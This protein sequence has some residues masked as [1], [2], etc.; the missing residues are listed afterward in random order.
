M[1]YASETSGKGTFK[2]LQE[3]EPKVAIFTMKLHY[4]KKN[5]YSESEKFIGTTRFFTANW[6]DII[7]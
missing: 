4:N 5:K 7:A 6:I 2:K 3:T 1:I